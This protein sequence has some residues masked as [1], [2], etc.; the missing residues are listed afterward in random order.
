MNK[1]AVIVIISVFFLFCRPNSN[2]TSPSPYI[3]SISMTNTGSHQVIIKEDY[4]SLI[5]GNNFRGHVFLKVWRNSQKVSEEIFRLIDIHDAWPKQVKLEPYQTLNLKVDLSSNWDLTQ[6]GQYSVQIVGK[7][8]FYPHDPWKENPPHRSHTI[9]TEIKSLQSEETLSPLE[10]RYQPDSPFTIDP[11]SDELYDYIQILSSRW[12]NF[13][14]SE[15]STSTISPKE[16]HQ[17]I[18]QDLLGTDARP[19]S[20]DEL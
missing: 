8:F 6:P 14:L 7:S 17:S 18:Y 13:T 19:S 1:I 5:F 2:L 15:N 3:V 11:D 16:V 10:V 4:Y 9:L 12:Y 20:S